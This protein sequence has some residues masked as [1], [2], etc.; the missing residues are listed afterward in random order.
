[1]PDGRLYVTS[2]NNDSILSYNGVTGAFVTDFIPTGTGGLDEPH[3][4]VVGPDTNDDGD[5]DLYVTSFANDSVLRYNARTGAFIDEAVYAGNEGLDGPTGLLFT[6]DGRLIV[7]SSLTDEVMRFNTAGTPTFDF[8]K[9][10]VENDGDRGIFDIDFAMQEGD[11]GSFDAELFVLDSTGAVLF[12]N[13]TAIIRYGAEGSEDPADP[14]LEVVFATAGEYYVMVGESDS[15]VAGGAGT[16]N[17]A[18][19]TDTYT[20]HFSIENTVTPD[21]YVGSSFEG[22]AVQMLP[23]ADSL[24]VFVAIDQRGDMFAFTTDDF[25]LMPANVF[26]GGQSRISTGVQD[27]MGITLTTTNMWHMSDARYDDKG[28]GL[29]NVYRR[30]PRQRV[31]RQ[32]AR[33]E[34][35]AGHGP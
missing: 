16:G 18:D 24:G 10:T 28:H 26:D 30:Q 9:F 20:L 27:V 21:D 25:A 23:G 22:L 12:T 34:R 15:D 17:R 11:P 33:A 8:Y 7:A 32:G 6:A 4:F 13:D 29:T 1:M 19:L 35:H 5:D 14:Y 2:S 3:Y 31:G